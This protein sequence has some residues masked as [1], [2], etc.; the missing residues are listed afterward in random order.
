MI[1]NY[2]PTIGKEN[3]GVRDVKLIFYKSYPLRAVYGYNIRPVFSYGGD[4]QLS[5]IRYIFKTN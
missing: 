3:K 4:R 5:Y 2:R 1:S